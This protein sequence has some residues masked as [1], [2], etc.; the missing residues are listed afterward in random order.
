MPWNAATFH[1]HNRALTPVHAAHAASV[2]NAILRR[3]GDEGLAIATA[4]AREAARHALGGSLRPPV[5][6]A[7]V[8]GLMGTSQPMRSAMPHLGGRSPHIGAPAPH[9]GA[10]MGHHIGITPTA[11]HRGGFHL[12]SMKPRMPHFDDGGTVSPTPG[13]QPNVSTAGPMAQ[14]YI[15]RFAQMTPE[16]LQEMVARLGNS[17]LGTIAQ[18]VLQAKQIM[19][20]APTPTQTAQPTPL[21]PAQS[22]Q[23]QQPTPTMQAPQV[24]QQAPQQTAATGGAMRP[25]RDTVPILAAGGEFV[26]APHHVARLGGGDIKEGHRR[27]DKFVLDARRHIINTTKKLKGPVQS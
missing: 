2:A 12:S 23:Q 17:P 24:A 19:P 16:Q 27:L 15:Q 3:S 1:H 9:I 26:I 7:A 10:S 13:L 22:Q 11:Q 18:R 20:A 8:G 21:S 4:N 25:K 14:S 5:Q 6:T